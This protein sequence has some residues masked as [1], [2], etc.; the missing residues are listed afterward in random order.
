MNYVVDIM[1]DCDNLTYNEIMAIGF[2]C[3]NGDML[4][5]MFWH[6][7]KINDVYISFTINKNLI[8]IFCIKTGKG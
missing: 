3:K 5:H 4:K 1:C 7:I 8:E 2:I 6:E